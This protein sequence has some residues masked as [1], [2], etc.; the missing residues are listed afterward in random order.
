LRS[1]ES[2]QGIGDPPLIYTLS[3][4]RRPPADILESPPAS[5][6]PNPTHFRI[7]SSAEMPKQR[8]RACPEWQAE[9]D[10]PASYTQSALIAPGARTFDRS[11]EGS[12]VKLAYVN[13]VPLKRTIPDNSLERKA[14]FPCCISVLGGGPGWMWFVRD[15]LS[16]ESP[17]LAIR[18]FPF[19]VEVLNCRLLRGKDSSVDIEDSY[20]LEASEEAVERRSS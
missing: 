11:A 16:S 15:E 7:G 14:A 19:D 6:R 2:K 5:P 1:L 9:S 13:I 18:G 10:H 8:T 17:R 12:R 4:R 20:Q 3:R